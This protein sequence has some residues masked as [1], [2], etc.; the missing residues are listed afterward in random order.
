MAL[1]TLAQCDAKIVE[2][3]AAFEEACLL[4]TRGNVGNSSVDLTGTPDRIKSLL[5]EWVEKR[6]AVINGGVA[7][8]TRRDC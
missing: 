3:Q 7:L 1:P 8:R 4:P 2:L 5:D 6:A